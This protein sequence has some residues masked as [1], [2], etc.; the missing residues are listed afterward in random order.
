ME[1]N[2]TNIEVQISASV[3]AAIVREQLKNDPTFLAE[4][5]LL[6]R[7]EIVGPMARRM[8]NTAD[9]TAQKR[10]PLASIPQVPG[11]QRVN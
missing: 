5:A 9:K 10:T 11:T 7:N 4:I 1:E 3:M 2:E 8:G 6:V